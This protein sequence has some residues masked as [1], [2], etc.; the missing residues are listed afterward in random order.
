MSHHIF[1]ICIGRQTMF[2]DLFAVRNHW[3]CIVIPQRALNYPV[4]ISAA[5][6][7]LAVATPGKLV[8]LDSQMMTQL[9]AGSHEPALAHA[10]LMGALYSVSVFRYHSKHGF[11]AKPCKIR[12]A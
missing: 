2:C 5:L 3:S 10:L 12:L 1:R 6:M 11:A 7:R 8:F 9:P 4:G